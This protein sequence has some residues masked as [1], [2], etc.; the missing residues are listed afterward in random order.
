MRAR[1]HECSEQN[2]G[3]VGRRNLCDYDTQRSGLLKRGWGKRKPVKLK[4]LH[5]GYRA[6]K[7]E[8]EYVSPL[9]KFHFSDTG[10]ESTCVLLWETLTYFPCLIRFL[11]TMFLT[12]LMCVCAYVQEED[13][14]SPTQR[15][16]A[17]VYRLGV[18]PKVSR[19]T[20]F[21]LRIFLVFRVPTN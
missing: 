3:R 16:K 4:K 11:G 17:L 5:L 18:P 7:I 6:L 2:R 9:E 20:L 13:E 10:E 8:R 14:H 1:I 15:F 19:V 21:G 12:F